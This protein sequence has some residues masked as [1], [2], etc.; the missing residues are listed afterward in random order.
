MFVSSHRLLVFDH[1]RVP[2]EVYGGEPHATGLSGR[3]LG[4]GALTPRTRPGRALRW[5]IAAADPRASSPPPRRFRIGPLVLTGSVVP[6][7]TLGPW[8][9]K[10]GEHWH[11]AATLTD[12]RKRLGAVWRNERGGLV[13]P[14]DP[15]EIVLTFWSERYTGAG[16][17][18]AAR[19]RPAALSAYYRLRPLLPRRAQLSARRL[20]S[21]VQA[22]APFPRWPVEPSL[23]GFLDLMMSWAAELAGDGVPQIAPWPD[24]HRWALV[25]THDVE[26]AAGLDQLPTLRDIEVDAGV[27]S[28]WNLVPRRYEVPDPLVAALHADGF[29][30]GIHGLHHD[31]RDLADG[32]LQQRLPEMRD[33]AGRWNAT[34]FRSPA[35]HRD[36]GAMSSL[37]FDYD[38]SYPD[39][40]PF[41][42]QP[43][44][45]CSWLPFFNGRIVEL[46]ITLPQ[47]HTIFVILKHPDGR[48]WTAKCEAIRAAGGMALMLTHPDY[49]QLAPIARAYEELLAR[50]STD[51]SAWRALPGDVSRWWRR[52]AASE[53]Q[54][55]PDGWRVAGPA[56]GEAR[57]LLTFP[58]RTSGSRRVAVE[59]LTERAGDHDRAVPDHGSD[60]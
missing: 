3:P 46:P 23:H 2:Y 34:G 28:S 33:W 51:E 43:G 60:Q 35:T 45:C 11:E 1:L 4:W 53:V 48:V 10:T 47:D 29:E 40:D 24:G 26:T 55:T 54:R 18:P 17:T 50:F 52:R 42:P 49:L 37:P 13:L 5:P 22:R 36:W 16:A 15:N 9:R 6:E 21:K 20:Y 58:A 14:F 38:S 41:E 8:L 12:G 27:R 7:D 30:I 39:T 25:L 19:L 56:S 32:V 31:G 44:G 57:I 59:H